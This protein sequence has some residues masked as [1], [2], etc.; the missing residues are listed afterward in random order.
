MQIKGWT[1]TLG[2]ACLPA[3]AV[4][5]PLRQQIP[6]AFRWEGTLAARASQ[7]TDSSGHQKESHA[8][9]G[10]HTRMCVLCIRA[11]A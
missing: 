6:A 11:C 4:S 7:G 9:W 1:F 3:C 2:P 5:S 8:S 10:T